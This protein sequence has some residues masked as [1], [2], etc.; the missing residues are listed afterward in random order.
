MHE[1]ITSASNMTLTSV[2]IMATTSAKNQALTS[3]Y[4]Q[5]SFKVVYH[6]PLMVIPS[7]IHP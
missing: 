5:Q 7:A 2:I 1:V 6:L 4:F 3:A